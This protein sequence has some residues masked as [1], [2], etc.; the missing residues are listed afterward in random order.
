MTPVEVRESVGTCKVA[1]QRQA[2]ELLMPRKFPPTGHLPPVKIGGAANPS[3][4]FHTAK[5]ARVTVAALPNTIK[6]LSPALMLSFSICRLKQDSGMPCLDAPRGV[7]Y[8]SGVHEHR[9]M[10]GRAPPL[11]LPGACL[12][13]L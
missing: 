9:P 4:R 12:G 13:D 3:R 8:H 11:P 10:I 2:P 5:L 6:Q 7:D 1:K